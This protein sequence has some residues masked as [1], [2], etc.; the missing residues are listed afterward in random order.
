MLL[1]LVLSAQ[2]FGEIADQSKV[3]ENDSLKTNSL[4]KKNAEIAEFGSSVVS[5]TFTHAKAVRRINGI[6]VVDV[7]IL[8]KLCHVTVDESSENLKA[9]KIECDASGFPTSQS[10]NN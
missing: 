4:T 10:K 9:S 3:A 2:A 7:L 5:K 1:L 6:A 8:D